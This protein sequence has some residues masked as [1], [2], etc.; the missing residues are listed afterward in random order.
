MHG[1]DGLYSRLV[2]E[3]CSWTAG[4]EPRIPAV[5]GKAPGSYPGCAK[6]ENWDPDA[7]GQA[8]NGDTNLKSSW[9]PTYGRK[10][11]DSTGSFWP[12]PAFLI[13]QQLADRRPSPA[14][15]ARYK[16]ARH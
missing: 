11:P 12:L 4:E 1:G 6:P 5:P 14:R 9:V 3:M 7:D 8:D 2:I 10:A 13:S 16:K 15:R